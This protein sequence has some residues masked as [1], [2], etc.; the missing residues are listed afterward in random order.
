GAGG[1][2][3][4]LGGGLGSQFI[5]C[6]NYS[7]SIMGGKVFIFV[8]GEGGAPLLLDSPEGAEAMKRALNAA[9]QSSASGGN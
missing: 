4:G 9:G 6:G 1:G 3:G 8:D 5:D 2:M 7:L